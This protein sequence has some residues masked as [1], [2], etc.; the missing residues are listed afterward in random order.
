MALAAVILAA[1]RSRRMQSDVPK[2]LHTVLG[3][4]LVEHVVGAA[5]EAGAERVVVVVSP[6]HEAA[7]AGALAHVPGVS[8]AVQA[9]PKGTGHALLAARPALADFAG[10]ALV[11]MG[12]VPCVSVESLGALLAGH[13]GG[14]AAASL[15]SAVVDD[16]TGYGRV[17]RDDA[18]A[19]VRLAEE[20]D[21]TAAE[22]AVAEINAGIYAL[23]MPRAF[24]LL[25][26]LTPSSETGELYLTQLVELARGAGAGV[27]AV[28]AARPD[29][30]LG[31]NDRVQLAEVTARLRRRINLG[32]MRRGVTF[33]A[34]ETTWVDARATLERDVRLEPFV[35]IQGPCRV[36]GGAV[37]GP[38][39]H[40]RAAT[41][42]PEARVGNFVEVVRSEVGARARALHLSY[43]G[44]AALG[45]D[46][47]VGA[48]TV[49]ANWDG[50]RHHRTEV[51]AGCSL[52]ANTTVVAPARLG[53]RSRT[54]AG[55]VV[56][57][58]DVA[59]GATWVGVPA[60]PA[61]RSAED[62]GGAR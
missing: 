62:S 8:L 33:V 41:V 2:V 31:V 30:V 53:A 58:D 43:V 6:D 25:D 23:E 54:G 44:D 12:D 45:D 47:N 35:V 11:L 29:D 40:L 1:G 20:K 59:P 16:P 51:G 60:R 14:S 34:P 26:G 4:T 42:G 17:L 10:T 50:D 18:G 28:A 37:V 32:H 38:F 9:E 13:R 57:K 61:T 55:A 19:P 5:R 46:V 36:A 7:V 21:A 27:Q 24:E 22:R 56:V 48:G 15:L 49:F 3:L 52:G 39:A